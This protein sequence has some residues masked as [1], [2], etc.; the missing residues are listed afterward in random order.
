MIKMSLNLDVSGSRNVYSRPIS[1]W[2]FSTL[3]I[4]LLNYH[5]LKL[6]CQSGRKKTDSLSTSC[7]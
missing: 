4:A 6:M 1:C 2:A 3:H 5:P 7:H